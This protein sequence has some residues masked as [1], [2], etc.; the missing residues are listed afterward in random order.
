MIAHNW[1]LS[2]QHR[3]VVGRALQRIAQRLSR[4][5]PLADGVEDL[6]AH[7]ASLRQDFANFMVEAAD[8]VKQQF[9]ITVGRVT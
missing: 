6:A 4:P 7:E 3:D 2:Y 5:L 9:D 8:F 1:L